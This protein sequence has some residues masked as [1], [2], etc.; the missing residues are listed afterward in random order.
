MSM[1]STDKG[2]LT[3]ENCAL[4]FIDQQP[5]ML[6]GVAS[7]GSDELLDK[8]VLLAKAAKVF[9]VPVVLTTV[10]FPALGADLVPELVELFPGQECIVRTGMNAWDDPRF[11]AA[12]RHCGCRNFVVAGLWSETALAFAVLQMLE[13]GY[14]MYVVEDASG[15]T[16]R[17]AHD[18]AIRRVE[19]AGA[20]SLTALQFLLELQRDWSREAHRAD[21]MAIMKEHCPALVDHCSK[22]PGSLS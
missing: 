9:R 2:L 10:D 13:E 5:P 19:Q 8:V 18:A 7:M 11:V 15:G 20:V 16:S 1:S 22:E 4:V 12:V 17:T 14:G 21:V 6:D 3:P